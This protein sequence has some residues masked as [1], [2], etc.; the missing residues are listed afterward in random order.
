MTDLEKF[1][2]LVKAKVFN[3]Q[4]VDRSLTRR[5]F[6]DIHKLETDP[7]VHRLVDIMKNP[8]DWN[9]RIH[10]WESLRNLGPQ[11]MGWTESLKQLIYSKD[12][13]SQ[14]FSAE[15]L[16]GV[17]C[18][19]NDAVPVLVSTL[20]TALDS[21]K[22]EW[23]RMACGAI[24]N[25]KNLSG[26]LLR[27]ALPVLIRA[28]DSGDINVRSYAAK[29]IGCWGPRSI[30]AVA[31][32]S[33]LAANTVDPLAESF[34]NT[35]RTIEPSIQT[36]TDGI[37]VALHQ[38][39]PSLRTETIDMISRKPHLI[40]LLIMELLCMSNDP[41]PRVRRA[42][43]MCLSLVQNPDTKIFSHLDHL[44]RDWDPTVSLAASYACIRLD[45]DAAHHLD[46]LTNHLKNDQPMIRIFSAWALGNLKHKCGRQQIYHLKA[47][48]AK[49][50]HP[51]TREKMSRA[52]ERLKSKRLHFFKWGG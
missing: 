5:V 14:I 28:L 4:H 18:C 17:P 24:G 43:A 6:D 11:I 19:E 38:N 33:I 23:A 31:R 46:N 36:P 51:V 8:S 41:D 52:L 9:A 45:H 47:A 29:T 40:S 35:L 3:L 25:Y 30:P 50:R 32:L 27:L 21:K 48:L 26:D 2:N 34:L 15:L 42:L 7:E 44:S 20:E 10:A 39:S 49:E 12:G 1:G 13:W 16:T 37:R 22:H